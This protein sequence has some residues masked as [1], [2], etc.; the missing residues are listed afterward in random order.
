MIGDKVT[1]AK[2]LRQ[3]AGADLKARSLWRMWAAR[4]ATGPS[5][6]AE[7]WKNQAIEGTK[8]ADTFK[9]VAIWSEA[10][11]MAFR[12]GEKDVSKEYLGNAIAVV[13]RT[14]TRWWR[15][16]ALSR[17]AKTVISLESPLGGR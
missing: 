13:S 2:S 16:R 6:D 14:Q 1:A 3:V 4:H 11:V 7:E 12:V 5:S 15:A 8:T 10:S 17:I 9:R